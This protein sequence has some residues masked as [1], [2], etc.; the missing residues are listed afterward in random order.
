MKKITGFYLKLSLIICAILLNASM[1]RASQKV[2]VLYAAVSPILNELGV[3]DK[4]VGVTKTDD[5]F[6]EA[7]KVG[8]HLKPNIELINALKPD[9]IITGSKKTFNEDML[10]LVSAQTLYYEPESL[11]EILENIT[12]L[13]KLFNRE[14]EATNLIEKLKQKLT[15]IKPLTNK[16]S[17]L[18]EISGEPLRV[19]GGKSIINS[20]IK[21]AGG[22]NIVDSDKKHVLL[23]QEVILS[24]NPDYY[25][26]QE[27][28]MNKNPTPPNKRD[29]FKTLS[30]KV[31]LVN[32]YDFSRPG[33]NAFDAAIMLNGILAGG[34]DE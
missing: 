15:Q 25:L 23:S 6:V 24:S 32:E 10:K 13:G 14:T 2:I 16:P 8:T 17:I 29:P 9:I 7:V 21:A 28:P 34:N 19:A 27:G 12:K 30:S 3:G 31:I 26:Y 11:D 18:F 22:R 5:V 33:I 1:A 20:I 4:I